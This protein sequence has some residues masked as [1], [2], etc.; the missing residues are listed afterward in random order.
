M[1]YLLPSTS[2]VPSPFLPKPLRLVRRS[3]DERSRLVFAEDVVSGTI[4]TAVDAAEA[5]DGGFPNEEIFQSL[6][7]A[8][9]SVISD[10][11]GST[12]TIG[13][14]LKVYVYDIHRLMQEYIASHSSFKQ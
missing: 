13:L 4:V 6:N 3:G 1:S 14:H 7:E 10:L 11:V 9:N 8:E 2:A 5:R 12:S